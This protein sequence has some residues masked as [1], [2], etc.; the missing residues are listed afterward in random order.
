[1]NNKKYFIYTE[2]TFYF[3]KDVSSLED[4]QIYI[5]VIKNNPQG[6]I[7][8]GLTT[9]IYQRFKSLSGSNGGGN[10]ITHLY[11]SPST[12]IKG[13]E[14]TC[15]SHFEYARIKGTEWF[16]G[17]KLNYEEV[18][19]YVNDLFYTDGYKRCNELRKPKNEMANLSNGENNEL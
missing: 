2:N 16:D 9:D 10:K 15:H 19:K 13:I 17:K 12:W 5:Y 6:N 11:C 8:I 7:K 1:M 18:V 14:K 4:G 3:L